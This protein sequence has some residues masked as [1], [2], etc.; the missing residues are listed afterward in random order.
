MENI[1]ECSICLEKYD[2]KEKLPRILAC[3]HTFCTFCLEKIKLKN[4]SEKNIKC[5]IDLK[6]GFETNN[7][8]D[9]PINRVLVDLID[10]NID[11]KL[12][13]EKNQK[14]I[15]LDA[16]ERLQSLYRIYDFSIQEINESLTYLLLSKEKCENSIIN[17]Y[18]TLMKKLNNRK[19]YMLNILYN[20]INEKNSFYELLL[21]KLNCLSK[22]SQEKLTKIETAIKIQEKNKISNSDQI[23]FITSLELDTLEDNDFIKQLNYVLNEIKSGYVPT[24][25]YD[26]NENIEGFAESVINYLTL[27]IEN[28]NNFSNFDNTINSKIENLN[29]NNGD[30]KSN[31]ISNNNNSNAISQNVFVINNENDN[32]NNANDN[33]FNLLQNENIN[34]NNNNN[35]IYKSKKVKE[36]VQNKLNNFFNSNV[37]ELNTSFAKLNLNEQITKLLW[38]HQ[39]TQNIFSLDLIGDENWQEIKNINNFIIPI[40]PSI[41]QL[42]NDTAF[43]SGGGLKVDHASKNCYFFKNGIFKEKA[44]MLCERRNHCSIRIGNYIYVCGGM[45]NNVSLMNTCEKYS[46]QYEKWIK[47]SALNIE[48]SHL[49]LCNMNNK[50]IYALGGEN[51]ISGLLDTIEKYSIIGDFWEIVKVRLPY[52]L[53]CV[54]CIGIN[55]KEMI[56]FGGYSPQ[57]MNRETIVKYNVENHQIVFSSKQ[58][59][60]LGWSIYMPIKIGKYINVILGG[61]ENSKPII[62][63]FEL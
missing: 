29:N 22:L 1:L 49:S 18:D 23:N 62:E 52:R 45:D 10:L 35:K 19:G 17:Y 47:C 2:K 56:I 53:E 61:D 32:G 24:V 57:K 48:R 44:D 14:N 11:E 25:L 55:H 20:Y 12:N 26:K 13:D 63:K 36:R 51:K 42:T 40:S 3:G 43:F 4:K 28:I 30:N 7:I 50:Y 16:R 33:N 46:L 54:A 58:L 39:G 38:F 9:I 37:Q 8:K 31:K 60:V 15:F 34:N 59:K 21:Q 41:I 5:P 27:N 6:I